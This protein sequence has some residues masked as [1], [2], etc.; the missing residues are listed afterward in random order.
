M[1]PDL[2]LDKFK[3]AMDVSDNDLGCHPTD[4]GWYSARLGIT[5]VGRKMGCIHHQ[6]LY[7]P[8]KVLTPEEYAALLRIAA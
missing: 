2:S 3:L 8:V 4:G 5:G 6:R 1:N 7:A